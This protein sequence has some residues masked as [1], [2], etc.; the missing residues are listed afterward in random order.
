MPLI[1]GIGD[2]VT[3]IIGGFIVCIILM[4]AWFSTHT[5]DIPL[6][7]EVGVIVV[8]LSQRRSRTQNNGV[9]D[10]PGAD[11]NGS[12]IEHEHSSGH[13]DIQRHETD[14]SLS[15]ASSSQIRPGSASESYVNPSALSADQSADVTPPPHL[16]SGHAEVSQDTSSLE[17][18]ETPVPKASVVVDDSKG[19]AYS[20]E[21][22]IRQRRVNYFKIN[23]PEHSVSEEAAAQPKPDGSK[24]SSLSESS[25]FDS[26][27]A[28]HL[29]EGADVNYPSNSD[30]T[31]T[32]GTTQEPVTSN[33]AADLENIASSLLRENI[34][35]TEDS[36]L[37]GGSSNQPKIRVKLK[38]MNETQR[39]VYAEPLDTIGDFRR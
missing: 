17:E 16:V 23:K 22:D 8:E 2:E 27:S 39:L 19:F 12:S 30:Q 25:L 29:N 18:S 28:R 14:N 21:E 3:V 35:D 24:L 7:R 34:N 4:F 15:E 33:S 11:L 1:E 6:L 38:Y 26:G 10:R 20:T 31:R 37:Q 36:S 5:A 9:E 13:E 32:V